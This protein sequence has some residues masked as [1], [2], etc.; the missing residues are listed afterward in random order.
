MGG[1]VESKIFQFGNS[2]WADDIIIGAKGTC[3]PIS[4]PDYL[5]E[6]SGERLFFGT[7]IGLLEFLHHYNTL[8]YSAE[9]LAL[10]YPSLD[11]SLIHKF[12]AFYLEHS[13]EVDAIVVAQQSTLNQIRT[14]APNHVTLADVRKRLP[15]RTRTASA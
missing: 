3:M 14:A 11:L 10:E 9:M 15:P 5:P 2:S 6:S 8:G 1:P 7:R 13:S 12:L 4:W